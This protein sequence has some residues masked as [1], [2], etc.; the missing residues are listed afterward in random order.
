MLKNIA[1][2]ILVCIGWLVAAGPAMAQSADCSDAQVQ[3]RLNAGESPIA[4]YNSCDSNMSVLY[5]KNYQGGLIAYLNTT[6]GPGYGSGFVAATADFPDDALW[7][8][9]GQGGYVYAGATASQ[10]GAGKGNTALIVQKL[11]TPSGSSSLPPGLYN[12]AAWIS[13]SP[14]NGYSDWY[15]PSQDEMSQVVNAVL[16]KV[17]G[18]NGQGSGYWTSTEPIGS[19]GRSAA[20]VDCTGATNKQFKNQA[21]S[22][23]MVRSFGASAELTTSQTTSLIDVTINGAFSHLGSATVDSKGI[24]YSNAPYPTLSGSMAAAGSSGAAFSVPMIGYNLTPGGTYYARACATV[25]ANGTQTALYGNQIQFVYPQPVVTANPA[26]ITQTTA[27]LGGSFNI[28]AGTSLGSQT[29]QFVEISNPATPTADPI[30]IS[31]G[32]GASSFGGNVAYGLAAGTT[33]NYKAG[34]HLYD[35]NNQLIGTFY[36]A[37]KS[38]TTLAAPTTPASNA[39]FVGIGYSS[40]VPTGSL[41]QG[42][43]MSCI[44]STDHTSGHC[45]FIHAAGG[46]GYSYWVLSPK[47][48]AFYMIIAAYH[49]LKQQP[50]KTW[51]FY[52][53]RYNAGITV[54]ST[55][56]TIEIKGD[57]SGRTIVVPW[58]SIPMP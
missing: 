58:S 2:G 18:C 56:Q 47:D 7:M 33:Y 6:T 39:P 17:G 38:F 48:N 49:S 46:N 35:S 26:D 29:F 50:V 19:A 40:D 21:L 12:Y 43:K 4:I 51:T 36:G 44:D 32:L 28:P 1:S 53:A 30:K 8:N 57:P 3:A 20:T 31:F 34:A 27:K 5:G 10:I 52:G 42:T 54:N 55:T 15:L 37:T 41:P 24:C 13:Q 45:D 11:G 22:V 23:R 16:K 25:T 9:Y 14:A